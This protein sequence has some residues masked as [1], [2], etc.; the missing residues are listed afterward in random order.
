MKKQK[1][2]K[3]KAVHERVICS[4]IIF[5]HLSRFIPALSHTVLHDE[6]GL[7][8]DLDFHVNGWVSPKDF[9]RIA[10]VHTPK[11]FEKI[12]LYS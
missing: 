3:N 11:Y 6:K 9:T 12:I 7:L 2:K 8:G 4:D 1:D 5:R 10:E